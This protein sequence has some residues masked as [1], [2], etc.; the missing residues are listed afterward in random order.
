MTAEGRTVIDDGPHL[1]NGDRAAGNREASALAVA[2]GAAAA[3]WGRR[4]STPGTTA[5]SA[6]IPPEGSVVA[7]ANARQGQR[8][9]RKV[10][11]AAPGIPPGAAFDRGG[12]AINA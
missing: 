5:A 10:D 8:S 9:A 6:A 2:P 4:D 12:P 7:L 11:A 1:R 3:A